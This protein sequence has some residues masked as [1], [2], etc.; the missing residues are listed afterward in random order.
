MV[1]RS[2]SSIFTSDLNDWKIEDFTPCLIA[3]Y[4]NTLLVNMCEIYGHVG[5]IRCLI[6]FLFF[7]FFIISRLQ[8]AVI[9]IQVF[10]YNRISHDINM[11]LHSIR[12]RVETLTHKQYRQSINKDKVQREPR[13]PNQL[14]WQVIFG[15][16]SV[17]KSQW[18]LAYLWSERNRSISFHHKKKKVFFLFFLN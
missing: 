16:C 5:H 4:L 9:Y 1:P 10:H 15:K 3:L 12:V 7:Y 18:W 17:R 6:E 11:I 14:D 8:V 13:H 2:V